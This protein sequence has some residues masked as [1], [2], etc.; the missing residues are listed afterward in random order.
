MIYI[1]VQNDTLGFT[2]DTRA[3]YGFG[4]AKNDDMLTP[5]PTSNEAG[6]LKVQGCIGSKTNNRKLVSFKATAPP[7]TASHIPR[8]AVIINNSKPGWIN[9]LVEKDNPNMK[10]IKKKAKKS[11]YG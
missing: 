10:K 4:C 7:P 8:Q 1:N 5:P 3:K 6:K 9:S 11:L 2:G